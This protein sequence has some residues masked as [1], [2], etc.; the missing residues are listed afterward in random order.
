MALPA[1]ILEVFYETLNG[2]RS[3]SSFEQ[4][5]YDTRELEQ[6]MS[7][8]DYMEL[9]A[10][11]YRRNIGLTNLL[12]KHINPAEF[13]LWQQIRLKYPQGYVSTPVQ[14]PYDEQLQR[15]RTKLE[16]AKNTDTSRLVFEADSHE[17]LLDVPATE[18]EV[19]AFEEQHGI[20][21][22]ACFRAFIRVI[23]N[24]GIGVQG[25]GAG[26]HY[27]IY[28]IGVEVPK[29]D[30]L[31]QNCQLDPDLTLAQWKA[32][33]EGGTGRV[34]NG[35]LPLGTQG[36]TYVHAIVLNGPYT[37]CVVNLD[38]TYVIPP[39]FPP[40][41]PNFLDYYEQWLDRIIDGTLLQPNATPYGYYP[42]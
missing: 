9:I 27:G 18:E 30:I 15:I 34:F 3:E 33:T 7:P 28:P 12:E 1:E 13:K 4:W 5:V 32:L 26:P 17:Y 41:D 8:D 35:L 38:Y 20:Q 40:G 39:I 16:T 31:Q 36:C 19:T 2:D 21:L 25:S 24:G 37:G 11:N 22:P 29:D 10:F 6:M 23:G 42:A 14:T